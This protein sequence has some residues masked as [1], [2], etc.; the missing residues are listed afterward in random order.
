MLAIADQLNELDLSDLSLTGGEPTMSHSF[1]A[2]LDRL[3]KDIPKGL[4][5]NGTTLTPRLLKTLSANGFDRLTISMDSVVPLENDA[6]RG[7]NS[8]GAIS[9]GLR[10][11]L[12]AG[13]CIGV[14][15]Q[16]SKLNVDSVP[17]S[18][19]EFA[20]MGVDSVKINFV[21]DLGYA[22]GQGLSLSISERSHVLRTIRPLISEVEH[23]YGVKVGVESGIPFPEL[24][25]MFEQSPC[26]CG[27][28]RVMIKHDGGVVPC[29][30][31][32]YPDGYS[33]LGFPVRKVPDDSLADI[34]AHD[35]LF[36]L[37]R[38]ASGYFRPRGCEGCRFFSFCRGGCRSQAFLAAH[39]L[40]VRTPTCFKGPL[41]ESVVNSSQE[42]DR[43][44]ERPQAARC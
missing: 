38:D 23:L 24:F 7:S 9:R 11:A 40:F 44:Y 18:I 3:R 43:L 16:V 41:Q 1:D 12:E 37:Y 28:H 31:M 20:R 27:H 14:P 36:Q 10:M 4:N 6:S 32:A 39:S 21:E 42:E 13:F 2:I 26:Y 34:F 8:Y 19:R 25:Q 33:K 17:S 22:I 15:V 35:L 29:D 5:T 30:A